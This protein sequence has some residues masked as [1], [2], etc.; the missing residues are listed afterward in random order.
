V[1]SLTPC[2]YGVWAETTE[3]VVHTG[4]IFEVYQPSFP[5]IVGE[6]SPLRSKP[7]N[8][9]YGLVSTS[10]IFIPMNWGAS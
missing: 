7:L 10:T 1:L 9:R 5:V 6:K 2:L 3:R 8:E 4:S